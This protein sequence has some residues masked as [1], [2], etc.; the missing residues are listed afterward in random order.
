[1][2]VYHAKVLF[3]YCLNGFSELDNVKMYCHIGHEFLLLG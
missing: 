2:T 3:A 1:L